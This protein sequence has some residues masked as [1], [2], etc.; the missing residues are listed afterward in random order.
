MRDGDSHRIRRVAAPVSA[1]LV[2]Q[3]IDRLMIVTEI[4][5]F[6]YLGAALGEL[7]ARKNN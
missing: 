2:A 6:G 1:L 4:R 5:F 7:S 3:R